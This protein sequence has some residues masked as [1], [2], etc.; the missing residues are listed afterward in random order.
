MCKLSDHTLYLFNYRLLM[1]AYEYFR[2]LC[3]KRNST[4]VFAINIC[5]S[6]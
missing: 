1:I 6:L 3:N 4:A 5:T 2:D